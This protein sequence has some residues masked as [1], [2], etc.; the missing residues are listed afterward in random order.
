MQQRLIKQCKCG[1]ELTETTK[2][3]PSKSIKGKTKCPDC[4]GN[5]E[6][7]MYVD[8]ENVDT[9]TQWVENVLKDERNIRKL[10]KM[11]ESE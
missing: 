1:Y 5:A 7:F 2:R 11:M 6:H 3:G 9:D 10:S 8:V 4:G